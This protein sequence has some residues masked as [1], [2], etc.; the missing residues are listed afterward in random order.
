MPEFQA[1]SLRGSASAT[2]SGGHKTSG[3]CQRGVPRADVAVLISLVGNTGNAD[4]ARRRTR[5]ARPSMSGRPA[6]AR[7]PVPGRLAHEL[8]RS[9]AARLH[10]TVV[11]RGRRK[12]IAVIQNEFGE[13]GIDDALMAA[14][15]KLLSEIKEQEIVEV[16]NGVLVLA[17]PALRPRHGSSSRSASARASGSSS[18][19]S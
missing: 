6:D 14:N 1:E 16:L 3:K 18:T 15:T 13:V 19:R 4:V 5:L 2:R 9:A 11:T 10:G 17:R 12:K 7:P 8:S